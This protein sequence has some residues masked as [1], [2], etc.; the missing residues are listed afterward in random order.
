MFA[1]TPRHWLIK[2]DPALV[3]LAQ[4]LAVMA[5]MAVLAVLAQLDN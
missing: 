1:S 4:W 3:T 2:S 5:V